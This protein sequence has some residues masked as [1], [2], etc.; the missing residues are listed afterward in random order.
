MKSTQLS[1]SFLFGS[2]L[3][4]SVIFS[5]QSYLIPNIESQLQQYRADVLIN[6]E[7]TIGYTIGLSLDILSKHRTG[8]LKAYANIGVLQKVTNGNANV[9]LGFQSH[10]EFYRGGLGTSV[11]NSEKYKINIELRNSFTV[12][13]GYD[14]NKRVTGKPAFVNVATDVSSL[15]DPL[16]YS[17][18]IGTMFI[19]GINHNRNQRIG[20]LS[21]SARQFHFN[22]YNDGPPFS[23]WGLSDRF[24]RFWSGGGQIGLYFKNDNTFMT[25]LVLRFDN[26]TG[27]QLNLYE[28][29]SLLKIDDLPYKDIKQQ[30]FNQARFQYKFGI[31]NSI[32]ATYSIFEPI[33]TDVQNIIHYNIS[34]SPFHAR[35]MQKRKLF[36]LEYNYNFNLFE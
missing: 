14:D 7:T 23:G 6:K 18:S 24:D 32:Y 30:M 26:Y 1:Y 5:Q 28:V 2:L 20:T 4:C 31:Q 11:L 9:L 10:I 3:F 35:P 27:Y 21:F 17:I 36:G 29:G 25:E 8:A 16:D 22:Y 12:L 33:Y 19:N 34:V 13:A 15:I